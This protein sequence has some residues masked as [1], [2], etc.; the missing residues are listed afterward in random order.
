M[1]SGLPR[2]PS[3]RLGYAGAV[4][5]LIGATW[6]YVSY[7][8][9]V[10]IQPAFLGHVLRFSGELK[11]DWYTSFPPPHWAID[12]LLAIVPE[13]LRAG[14]V[15]GLWLAAL[16]ILWTSFIAI[17]RSLG[18]PLIVAI[19]AGL[20]LIPTRIGGF[21]VS[22]MLFDF[23][24]PSNLAFGFALGSLAF[25][26]RDR[27]V[28]AGVALGLATLLHPQLGPLMLV[29]FGP[30]ALF[31]G[32]RLD[33]RAAAL[34]AIPVVVLGAPSGIEFIFE[35]NA[36]GSLSAHDKYELIAIVRIPYQFHYSSFPSFE[37]VRTGLWLGCLV[38]SLAVLWRVRAARLVALLV[39]TVLVLCVAGAV[40]GEL[41][42]PVWLVLAQ[43]S[44]L[45]ALVVLLGVAALAAALGRL[46]APGWAAVTLVGIFLLAPAVAGWLD[47]QTPFGT[48][49]S[50]T[51]AGMLLALLGAVLL[52]IRLRL[53]Q[54]LTDLP[55][56]AGTRLTAGAV[57]I[58]FA[59]AALSMIVEHE[60]RAGNATAE[61]SIPK[62]SAQEDALKE[63]A[64]AARRATEPGQLVFSSPILDGMREYAQ[65]PTVVEY[66]TLLFGK[67]DLE[68]RR[69]MINLTGNPHI[70]DPEPFGTDGAAR[71]QAIIGGF[72]KEIATSPEE[73][74]RYHA[75]VVVAKPLDRPPPW[76]TLAYRNDYYALYRLDRGVCER[77]GQSAASRSERF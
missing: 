52:A 71:A 18:A 26:L 22:E 49:I 13:S 46:L 47:L 34:F 4:A 33:L 75:F 73:P 16:A 65:R 63:V 28:L 57:A 14:A 45:S 67:G 23:F 21:G 54:R 5:F 31:A 36:G 7:R 2:G 30:L 50:A 64:G 1:H 37:Y 48:A 29:A 11:N 59:A 43:T 3:S 51:E 39:A 70:V 44:R 27:R 74:C 35:Q 61:G 10:A 69:R 60:A 53:F 12:H 42:S 20:I 32:G 56:L 19:A 58:A 55:G 24:Y 17:C 62:A 9:N 15:L 41:G 76:L 6:L 77:G 25:L 72:Q 40:A 38:S 68:W 8:F 66:G